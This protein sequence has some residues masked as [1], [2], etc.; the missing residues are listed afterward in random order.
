VVLLQNA[1]F[2]LSKDEL[3]TLGVDD[4]Q[5]ASQQSESSLTELQS[6]VDLTYSHGRCVTAIQWLPHRQVPAQALP[7][8][9]SSW[10]QDHIILQS[11]VEEATW[12]MLG[13]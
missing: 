8:S 5:T 9:H 7:S 12:Q 2:D 1:L 11:F 10:T 13:L 6:F 3:A 4:L